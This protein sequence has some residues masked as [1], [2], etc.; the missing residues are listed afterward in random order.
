MRGK[1][2]TANRE[3]TRDRQSTQSGMDCQRSA[4]DGPHTERGTTNCKHAKSDPA[5][6]QEADRYPADGNHTCCEAACRK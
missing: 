2:H 5:D 4:S 1:G 6:R 3:L